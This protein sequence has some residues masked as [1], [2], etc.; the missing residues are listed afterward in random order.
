MINLEQADS[1]ERLWSKDFLIVFGVN[2]LLFLCF[3]LLVVIMSSYAKNEFHAS[4]GMAGLASSIF[5]VGALIGRLIG[6][7]IIERVGRKKL[8][9]TGLIAFSVL[10]G[11]YFIVNSLSVLLIVRFFHGMAF[12]LASTATGTIAASL[13]PNSRRGEGTGYYG[14]SIIIA[15]AIGPFIGLMINEHASMTANFTLCAVLGVLS[16][17]SAF[18]IN[19][20]KLMLTAEQKKDLQGL[21]LSNFIEPKALPISL[22]SFVMGFGY[23][24][25]LTYLMIF[26]GQISLAQVASYFF[27][28]Y[29]IVV[30]LSRPFTG[31]WFDQRG[32]NVVMYPAILSFAIGMVLL[33][34]AHHGPTLLLSAVFVGLGY[35][36]T[37]SSAQALAI[38][39]SPAH[40]IGLATS[41][42][43]IFVDVGIGFGPFIL[44]FL[45]PLVG[46]RGMY[47]A[48]AILL[49][50]GIVL[51]HF[52]VGKTEKDGNDGHAVVQ[53]STI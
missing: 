50:A 10:I 38:K 16:L 8:L 21:K 5:V 42:F 28:V 37:Q 15:S 44:G 13:I 20:P 32:A 4:T 14:V 26:A 52:L 48:M 22:V 17:L 24:S 40:R 30:I 46:F 19:I 27:I 41:T 31:R 12:A 39:R 1:R 3:Y 53:S 9:F 33:S 51:Y 6:G 34:Q 18:F 2:F 29:A 43:Y 47:I 35:G 23:S 45:T 7:S 25:I 11:L 36:T 49:A